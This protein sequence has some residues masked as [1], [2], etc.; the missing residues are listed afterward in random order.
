MKVSSSQ[1][2]VEA[3][4][5]FLSEVLHP[6]DS[7]KKNTVLPS[8][9]GSDEE[10]PMYEIVGLSCP[11]L[12]WQYIDIIL[13]LIPENR[14]QRPQAEDVISKNYSLEE[15]LLSKGMISHKN[16]VRCEVCMNVGEKISNSDRISKTC[17]HWNYNIGKPFSFQ[18]M[19]DRQC[20]VLI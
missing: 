12:F 11:S 6:H 10:I 9:G 1:L 5:I 17:V 20:P 13:V 3:S 16:S 14:H 4:A 19:E 18:V 15:G 2:T 7:G 8:D